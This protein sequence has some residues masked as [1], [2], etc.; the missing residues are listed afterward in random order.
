MISYLACVIIKHCLSIYQG[1]IENAQ[2]GAAS[3]LVKSSHELNLKQGFLYLAY[4]IV[5]IFSY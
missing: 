4:P 3:L 5:V 1:H 2:K